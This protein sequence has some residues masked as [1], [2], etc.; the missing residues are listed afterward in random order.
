MVSRLVKDL[1]TLCV[2]LV[3]LFVQV[4]RGLKPIL[5][6]E[7][8]GVPLVVLLVFSPLIRSFVSMGLFVL[9]ITFV[10]LSPL[11]FLVLLVSWVPF[12]L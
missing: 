4:A 9:M 11:V 1:R 2:V 3:L 10:V 5:F 7:I 8:L 12:V 6:L